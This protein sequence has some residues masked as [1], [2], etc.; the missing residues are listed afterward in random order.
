MTMYPYIGARA[1]DAHDHHLACC[2]PEH[3]IDARL[4][5]LFPLAGATILD[6]GAGS[7]V[8]ACR[9]AAAAQE[10]LALE[11]DPAMRRQLHRRLADPGAPERISV[12][13]GGAERMPVRDRSIDLV[14]ARF[15]YFFGTD[16]CL[17]G[18][19]EA[20]RVVRPGGGM[21]VIEAVADCPFTALHWPAHLRDQGPVLAFW[22]RQGF[23]VD[24]IDTAYAAPDRER[25]RAG[26]VLEN[27][28]AGADA[29][30]AQ[31]AGSSIPWSVWLFH[32]RW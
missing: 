5:A 21:A 1:A 8:H 19:A 10:V 9:L 29:I 32:R 30:L 7:G 3:R 22:R 16:A 23:A 13:A 6:V 31:V 25:L 28:E 27:G 12:L 17:P 26:L 15:A 24:R 11:P 20:A 14:H 4:Q 2:D 18:L